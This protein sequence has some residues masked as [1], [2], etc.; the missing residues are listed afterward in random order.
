M[1]KL[2]ITK[3]AKFTT[4]KAGEPLKTK[5]GKPYTSVRIQAQQY[6]DTWLSGF[7]SQVT[8]SWKEGDEIEVEVTK[9]GEYM[10]WSLPKKEDKVHEGLEAIRNAQVAHTILLNQ[11]LEIIKPRAKKPSDYPTQ[12][13]VTAFDEG[14]VPLDDQPF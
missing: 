12:S 14:D 1:E 6:G 8:D 3:I 11:I 7:G 9:N 5:T 10:N 2:T 4:N 13:N